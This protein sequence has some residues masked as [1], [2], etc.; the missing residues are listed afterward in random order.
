VTYGCWSAYHAAWQQASRQL[1]DRA[2]VLRYEEVVAD[3]LAA[4]RQ[5]SETLGLTFDAQAELPDFAEL[6]G[7]DPDYFSTGVHQNWRDSFTP[8]Q[9][10]RLIERNRAMIEN[11]GLDAVTHDVRAD[12]A[13][14]R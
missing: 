4:C 6:K 14:T 9:A 8:S 10:E 12:S 7:K 3:P 2:L 5:I 13:E 11:M 1:A